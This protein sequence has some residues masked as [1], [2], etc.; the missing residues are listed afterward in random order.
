MSR[1]KIIFCLLLFRSFWIF[2]IKKHK[3]VFTCFNGKGYGDSGKAICDYMNGKDLT[4]VWL[5]DNIQDDSFPEWVKP[6]KNTFFGRAYHLATAKIWVDNCRKQPYIRKRR[7]QFYIQTWHGGFPLKK[8]EKAVED[9]LQEYYIL[10]AKNDS[11]MIDVLLSNNAFLTRIFKNDFWYDGRIIE[12]GCP[13]NDVFFKSNSVI[14]NK[15][16]DVFN[17]SKDKK[18]CLYAPTFRADGSLDA[19]NIDFKQLKI[20]LKKK[21]GN[22]W[23][24]IVRLHPNISKKGDA[25]ANC[26]DD[27]VNA[28]EYGDMQELL[29]AS[30]FMITDY[31]SCIFDYAI[32]RKNCCIYASDIDDYFNN[33][34]FYIHLN[35][36]PFRIATDNKELIDTIEGFNEFEHKKRT[37]AFYKRV[38]SF[39]DGNGAE[40]VASVISDVIDGKYNETE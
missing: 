7:Q 1:M 6:V 9:K 16:R 20:A 37:D 31:S 36:C 29:V 5:V 19:Y 32:T 10:S 38:E 21:F 26:D 15:I 39:E 11:R 40:T 14:E 18:I 8:I 3:I 25:L 12:C 34:G 23:V 35:E 28:S 4:I 30:D 22:N 27:I 2:P 33:R 24:I 17:I 13:R